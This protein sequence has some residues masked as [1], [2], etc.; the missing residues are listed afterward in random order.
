MEQYLVPVYIT[1]TASALLLTAGLART[2]Y[3]N[4]AV[5]LK[6][7]FEDR[8]ELAE[9]VNR[10]LVTGFYMFNLGYAFFLMQAHG[11]ADAT[12]A[13]EVLAKKL[14]LLL[15][16]MAVTHFLNMFVIHRIGNRRRQRL[17]P[18]PVAPQ[19]WTQPFEAFTNPGPNVTP[20]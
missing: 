19:G 20:A 12:E 3:R 17:L 5:F 15:V 7:E 6:D 2:L 18:P 16:S 11:A 1:Y 9:A 10:M 8:P 14:G 4:G 13:F